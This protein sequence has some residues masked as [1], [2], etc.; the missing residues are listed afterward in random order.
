MRRFN[1]DN[2]AYIL[3]SPEEFSDE[4]GHLCSLD[5]RLTGSLLLT[6]KCQEG[7]ITH[8]CE[9]GSSCTRHVFPSDDIDKLKC[10]LQ[11]LLLVPADQI[12]VNAAFCKYH[13]VR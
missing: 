6:T 12:S 8:A 3:Q 11:K 4:L 10:L 1:R 13:R 5:Q 9:L 2:T 7:Q